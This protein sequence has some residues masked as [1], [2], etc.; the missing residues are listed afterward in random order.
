[1]FVIK[2]IDELFVEAEVGEKG[3][4]GL[5][6][7]NEHVERFVAHTVNWSELEYAEHWI[8]ALLRVL[9]G[10]PSALIT[11]MLFPSESS[12]LVWWPMWRVGDELVF[13][14]QLLFFKQHGI[15]GAILNA[16]QLYELIGVHRS[17]DGDNNRLSEWR[18]AVADV[19]EF[20]T[21]ARV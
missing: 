4:M 5:L 15:K 11:D 16:D 2:F 18:V 13:Q 6:R 21:K 8:S 3:R 20:I 14:N 12:H 9:E 10:K 19:Q 17:Y 7:L 1:M